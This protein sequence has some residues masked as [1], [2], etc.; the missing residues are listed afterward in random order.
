MASTSIESKESTTPEKAWKTAQSMLRTGKTPDEVVARLVKRG[1]SEGDAAQLVERADD[2]LQEELAGARGKKSIDRC[3]QC[4]KPMAKRAQ[5]CD[6]CGARVIDEHDRDWDRTQIAPHLEKGRKWIGAVAILY[7][8]GGVMFFVMT[9]DPMVLVVNLVLAAIQVGLW[10]WAKSSLLP[11]AVTALAL[12]VTVHLASA[13]IEPESLVRGIIVKIIFIT[14]LIQTIRAALEAR[15]L[16]S[17]N[18]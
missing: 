11:A 4:G 2:A 6:G 15:S 1:M 3:L 9:E 7:A 14:V 10:Q 17:A 16:Q 13:I 12:F 5:F 8:L 18:A